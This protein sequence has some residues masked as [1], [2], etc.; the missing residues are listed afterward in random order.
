MY[1]QV[2]P[3]QEEND[4]PGFDDSDL[5]FTQ[6]SK[7][8]LA[9]HT[10]DYLNRVAFSNK[11][12]KTYREIDDSLLNLLYSIQTAAVEEILN[13]NALTAAFITLP[14][15]SINRSEKY[16]DILSYQFSTGNSRANINEITKFL[17]LTQDLDKTEAAWTNRAY[18]HYNRVEPIL[19]PASSVEILLK[20]L[21]CIVIIKRTS[22]RKHS[23]MRVIEIHVQK[24]PDLLD[25]F[26]HLEEIRTGILAGVNSDLNNTDDPISSQS[27]A[28]KA[29][30]EPP[31]A[32]AAATIPPPQP[33]QLK[34]PR[35]PKDL[36][37]GTQKAGRR[38][39]HCTYCLL[40]SFFKYF[41]QKTQD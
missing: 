21:L 20:M 41:Y 39:D 22:R 18:E 35:T 8:I 15:S 28:F 36:L 5:D 38:T 6:S 3:T 25:S 4:D 19:S 1:T 24:Y 10:E 7:D 26:Q 33:P 37:K 16:L 13:S 2:S 17:S 11:R 23:N 32:L 30:L 27:S 34:Q 31:V 12:I 29:N 40:T 9:Q 14:P